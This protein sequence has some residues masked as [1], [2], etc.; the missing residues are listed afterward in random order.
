ML[1]DRP[2][3]RSGYPRETTSALTW[4]LCATMAGA[5]L[6]F[7]FHQLGN[8]SVLRLLALSLVGIQ[9]W[10]LWTLVSYAL[11]HDGLLHLL[12]NG[13]ML[14]LLGREVAPLLGSARF[15]QFYLFAAALGAGAWLL[16]NVLGDGSGF[17]IGSSACVI[18]TLIFFACVYPER[19]IT[20]LV[21]FILPVTLKPKVFAW[22]LVGLEC[23]GLALC[24]VPGAAFPTSIA[25]S[26]H[27]GGALAAW[28]FY[29]FVYAAGG[30]DRVAPTIELPHWFRRRKADAVGPASPRPSQPE[31][32]APRDLRAEVDRIL[33]KINAHGFGALTENEKRVLDD[34]KEMLSRR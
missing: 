23:A 20:F 29:R 9:D 13:L 3:M 12:V 10:Q 7:A 11:L 14:Y 30:L 26:A 25:H 6:Q 5:V 16:L 31:E 32:P 19:E 8:D 27:L 33:D 34:A 15:L 4:I 21:F 28:L 24:E 2:Y 17:L 1:S 18:A 22:I